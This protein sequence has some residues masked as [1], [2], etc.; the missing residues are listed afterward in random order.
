LD[1][2]LQLGHIRT[3][4]KRTATPLLAVAR[5]STSESL[6]EAQGWLRDAKIAIR[7]G[8]LSALQS[9][10]SQKVGF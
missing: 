9:A 7:R 1:A 2:S 3:A 10:M 5:G 8:P 6:A 4:E